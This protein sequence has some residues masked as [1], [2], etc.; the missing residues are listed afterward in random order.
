MPALECASPCP[1]AAGVA[2]AV[3]VVSDVMKS[4]SMVTAQ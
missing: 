4:A 1:F 3:A 2:A